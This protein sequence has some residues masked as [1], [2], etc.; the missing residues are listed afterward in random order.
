[1]VG[2]QAHF[3][4]AMPEEHAVGR[5]AGRSGEFTLATG[6]TEVKWV[7][8]VDLLLVQRR[9]CARPSSD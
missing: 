1:M 3:V 4:V 5:H 7:K 6:L 2:G 9:W 8:G